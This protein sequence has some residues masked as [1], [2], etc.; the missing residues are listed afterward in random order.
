MNILIVGINFSPE[1]IGI[2]PYTSELAG[3]LSQSGHKI[4]VVTAKPYYPNWK[5][6]P[7]YG[8]RGY[9]K[10][11]ENGIE[12]TRCPL[13]VPSNPTG[14]RRIL[15]HLS[16]A[17]SAFLPIMKNVLLRRPDFVI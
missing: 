12:I 7:E 3:F 16:F 11:C 1:Q 17:A 9:L 15:H 6:A 5:I 2:G 13:Y 14:L 8:K 10:S 4:S